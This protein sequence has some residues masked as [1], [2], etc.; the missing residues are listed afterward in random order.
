[1]A[2]QTPIT[3][4][5]ALQGITAHEYVLPAIQREFVWKPEQICAFFDSLMR[6]YPI[7]SFLFW[8]IPA[9]DLGDYVF[10]D[11]IRNYHERRAAHCEVVPNDA[12]PASKPT[13][14]ILDG[15][16][17]MTALNVGL[18]GS[19]A[20][21]LPRKHW[22]NPDAFPKKKL[23]LNIAAQAKE[24]DDKLMYDFRF[25]TKEEATANKSDGAYWF[26]VPKIRDLTDGTDAG[27]IFTYIQKAGLA[28]DNKF[29]FQ[30]LDRL[31][32][33]VFQ[34]GV[35]SYY[36]V[37]ERELDNVLDIFIRVNS[38]GTVLSYSDL[39]LSIATA[40]WSD[41]DA[42]QDINAQVDEINAT[43]K[44][45]AFT[46]DVVLK[47]GL[48]LSDIGDIR[49]KVTNFNR[50]NMHKLEKG[51]D[52]IAASLKVATALLAA[53]GFSDR[54]LAA[55]YVLLPL[56]YYVK[57]RG[58]DEAYVTSSALDADRKKVRFWVLRSLLKAGIW[59]S[60][61]DTLLARLREA[62]RQH[63]QGGF[64][65]DQIEA[66]MAPIGKSLKF[67]AEEID[68]LLDLQ[69][70]K[71]RTFVTLSLLYP[72]FSFETDVHVDHVFPQKLFFKKALA[73]AGVPSEE[74]EDFIAMMNGLP[75]LQLLPGSV[76]TQKQAV[77]PRK[78]IDGLT[79]GGDDAQA[80]AG[81]EA[82]L[83]QH[84]LHGL[85]DDMLGFPD[86]FEARRARMRERLETHLGV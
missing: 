43:G 19:H 53:F 14:A 28:A 55:D 18:R 86:F 45:F 83:A 10:Y 51:W 38:G 85:P 26:P 41:R 78:W 21:R 12:L 11:F 27:G 81:R 76:N 67:G 22:K 30:A 35:V 80:H 33:L 68:E 73:K 29:A 36:S 63:G 44:G 34:D 52:S 62:I 74:Q 66:A 1:M 54:T 25:L 3:I 31:R 8:E 24:N 47:G 37:D 39:L 71:P 13:V 75:N 42:R 40:Q 49:F 20:R 17:R 61:Q 58:F 50:Q 84:D 65:A 7:G 46:K 57:V 15:Q 60:G 6:R 82:Y 79:V 32:Q 72:K 77:L 59:G 16:Q 5:K 23:Y 48:V 69:Y 2:F 70:G 56:A 64:P 4:E 9:A